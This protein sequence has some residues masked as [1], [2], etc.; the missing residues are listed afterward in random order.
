MIDLKAIRAAAEAATPGPWEA[1]GPSFGAPLPKYLNEVGRINEDEMFEEVCVSPSPEDDACSAD[2][3]FIATA[4]PAA[5]LE[6]LDRLEA[7]EKDAA[8]K[9]PC[10]RHCES[11]AF[12]IE[13]RQLVRLTVDYMGIIAKQRVAMK[14]AWEVL[15]SMDVAITSRTLGARTA[16]REAFDLGA[17]MKDEQK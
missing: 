17:A 3:I 7:A 9:P 13:K 1:V 8:R 16:L 5:I 14:L 6:L 15:G 2:M 10:A 4:N 11:P 12:E